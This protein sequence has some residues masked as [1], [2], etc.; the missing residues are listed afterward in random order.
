MVN[1]L[2]ILNRTTLFVSFFLLY[3]NLT[4]ATMYNTGQLTFILEQ[5]SPACNIDVSEYS[6]EG[7]MLKFDIHFSNCVIKNESEVQ[8]NYALVAGESNNV[9]FIVLDD[10]MHQLDLT[11]YLHGIDERL[12]FFEEKNREYE[13]SNHTVEIMASYQ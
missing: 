12:V 1:L 5:R 2:L 4:F 8:I 13:K 6:A 10:D 11:H 7:Q 9:V 3:S